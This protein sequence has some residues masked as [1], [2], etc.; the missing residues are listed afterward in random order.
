MTIECY[1]SQCPKHEKDEPF[2]YERRCVASHSE[3]KLYALTRT[4]EQQGYDI[5][6]LERDNPHNAW[7]YE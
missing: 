1:F 2:C 7:M 4:L 3:I 6:A 5:N